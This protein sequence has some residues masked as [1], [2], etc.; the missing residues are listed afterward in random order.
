MSHGECELPKERLPRLKL[1]KNTP[2]KYVLMVT[3][4]V[5]KC[6]TLNTVNVSTF[7]VRQI[8]K[9]NITQGK[10]LLKTNKNMIAWPVC[11]ILLD[12][13]S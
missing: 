10:T 9:G 3:Y 2:K 5:S 7:P 4:R 1:C 11:Q 13:H 12:K 6:Q 8:T